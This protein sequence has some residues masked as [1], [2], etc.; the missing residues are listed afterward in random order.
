MA[1]GG[2]KVSA[3]RRDDKRQKRTLKGVKGGELKHFR[4]FFIFFFKSNGYLI[5][6]NMIVWSIYLKIE[7][8]IN[9]IF[10]LIWFAPNKL[11]LNYDLY[12][13][14][15]Y[16]IYISIIKVFCRQANL[17]FSFFFSYKKLFLKEKKKELHYKILFKKMLD[18]GKKRRE[19]VN[20]SKLHI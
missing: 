15:I 2:R 4:V 12:T 17:T 6:L 3:K 5:D 19:K 14:L 20:I 9:H 16:L 18:G 10:G 13:F 1:S 8:Q 7:N 11:N